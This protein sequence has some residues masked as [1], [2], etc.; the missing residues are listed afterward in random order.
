MQAPNFNLFYISRLSINKVRKH[1]TAQPFRYVYHLYL[2]N[3]K[4]YRD[5]VFDV[6]LT[7]HHR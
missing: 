3:I 5:V 7:V 1:I 2:E 6:I 4:I